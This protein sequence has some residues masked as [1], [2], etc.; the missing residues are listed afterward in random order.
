MV[1][2][3]P[4]LYR[5]RRGAVRCSIGNPLPPFD[6]AQG[7]EALEGQ[8]AIK[9]PGHAVGALYP[10]SPRNGSAPPTEARG[11]TVDEWK[12]KASAVD[13]HWLDCLVGCAVAASISGIAPFHGAGPKRV[14][15]KRKQVSYI[16]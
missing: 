6:H 11:R 14:K 12:L 3:R 7:P 2:T 10:P 9:S 8:S 15:R 1:E 13:N 4:L 16:S 5:D